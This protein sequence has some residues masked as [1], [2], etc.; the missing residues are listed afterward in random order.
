MNLKVDLTTKQQE[1]LQQLNITIENKDYSNE[2]I[3][4]YEN[5]ITSHIMNKSSKNGDLSKEISK[6]GEIVNKLMK[7]EC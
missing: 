4:Q 6:Y 5:I 7:G 2:E 1:L 3:R